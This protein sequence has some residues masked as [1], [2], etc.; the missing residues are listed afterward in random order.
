MPLAE[1]HYFSDALGM[2]TAANVILPNRKFP[3]PYPVMFLLHGLS[4]DHTIWLRHTSIERYVS[5]LPLIVVMP[6]GGRGFYCDAVEGFAYYTAI[7]VELVDV[8]RNY[9]PTTDNWCVSGLSMGGYGAFRL[10]LDRPELFQSATALSA[11]LQFGHQERFDDDQWGREFSRITGPNPIGGKDDLYT[12]LEALLPDRVPALRIDCGSEDFLIEADRHY[13][14]FLDSKGV[15]HE[16]EEHPG[17]HNWAYWDAQIQP[18]LEFHRR[19]L[20][21]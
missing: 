17:E 5:E 3:G 14:A 15:A 16:Y 7:G 6:N 21:I 1:L 12:K 4:D 19:H 8:V 13:H 9:F 20:G 18:A 2:Q 10:A 11:A